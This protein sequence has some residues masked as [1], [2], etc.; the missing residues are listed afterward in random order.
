MG[1]KFY[2]KVGYARDNVEIAPGVVDSVVVERMY[3][4]DISRVGVNA[5][6]GSDILPNLDLTNQFSLIADAYAFE[7]FH[8]LAYLQWAG[9]YWTITQVEVQRP[10]LIVRVGGVYHGPTYSAPESSGETD[11]G[12]GPRHAV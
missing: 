9:T 6:I 4:G 8:A 1:A 12:S 2:G 10:R 3:R 5:R 7:N 11:A